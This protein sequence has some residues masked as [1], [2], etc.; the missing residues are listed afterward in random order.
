MLNNDVDLCVWLK[1][2]T[3]KIIVVEK[4]VGIQWISEKFYS[5]GELMFMI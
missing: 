1:T 2:W 3:D 4:Y 5:K